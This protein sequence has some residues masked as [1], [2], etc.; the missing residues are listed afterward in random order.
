MKCP[1]CRRIMKRIGQFSFDID[2]KLPKKYY[3]FCP[4]KGRF[5]RQVIEIF[6]C[7]KCK[8]LYAEYARFTRD[9]SEKDGIRREFYPLDDNCDRDVRVLVDE[10]E[11]W[12]NADEAWRLQSEVQWQ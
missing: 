9:S 11:G 12:S 3:K 7:P 5:Y 1:M 2:E 8:R 4:D 10:W 6:Y